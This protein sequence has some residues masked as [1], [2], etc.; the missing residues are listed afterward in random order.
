MGAY[1]P[2]TQI[3]SELGGAEDW[4]YQYIEPVPGENDSMKDTATRDKLLLAREE[5]VKEYEKATL[6]WIHATGEVEAVKKRRNEIAGKL[7][8]DYWGLDPYI[9]ARSYYDRVGMI[10]PGGKI[11]FYPAKEEKTIIPQTEPAEV[12]E[13]PPTTTN[14]TKIETSEADL[15]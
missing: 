10:N 8:T 5:I 14:G 2:R 15:D 1:V 11:Q 4:T 12:A 3:I 13:I 9:R 6:E 7:K